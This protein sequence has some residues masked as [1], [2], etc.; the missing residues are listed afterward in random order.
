MQ[1]FAFAFVLIGFV[2]DLSC[3]QYIGILLMVT[4]GVL[5]TENRQLRAQWAVPSRPH[6]GPFVAHGG[7][8]AA[9]TAAVVQSPEEVFVT[10][11]GVCFHK[12]TCGHIRGKAPRSVRRCLDCFG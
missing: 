8:A 2:Q 10:T 12:G 4:C 9:A 3:E 7:S 1:C 11:R 6:E 5:W